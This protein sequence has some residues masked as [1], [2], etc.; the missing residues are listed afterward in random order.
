MREVDLGEVDGQVADR[1]MDGWLGMYQ[2]KYS[3]QTGRESG[4]RCV[5]VGWE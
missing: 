3:D 2:S 1:R 4:G 5:W